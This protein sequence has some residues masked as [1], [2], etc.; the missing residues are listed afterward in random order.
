MTNHIEKKVRL[1]D[2]ENEIIFR[3]YMNDD[4]I[5]IEMKKLE[6]SI[7]VREFMAM[8]GSI[9]EEGAK[10]I[11]AMLKIN[12]VLVHL[13]ISHNY[14]A[15]EGIRYIFDSL[16][17]NSTLTYLNIQSNP[18]WTKGAEYLS[19]MLLINTTLKTLHLDAKEMN[20]QDELMITE[21]LKINSTLQTLCISGVYYWKKK[22]YHLIC[23]NVNW[24]MKM[25]EANYSKVIEKY[26]WMNDLI[27]DDIQDYRS[28]KT[29][30]DTMI[31]IFWTLG[32]YFPRDLIWLIVDRKWLLCCEN[33]KIFQW[34]RNKNILFYFI[35]KK[36]M[37][38]ITKP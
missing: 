38:S 8:Y 6:R 19:K 4:T 2:Y 29:N 34:T 3:A 9:T 28:E 17:T 20:T 1:D 31:F 23:L 35:F 10:D 26:K 25:E 7:V 36:W 14:I 24:N 5:K 12:T 30:K 21:S 32:K 13:D 15:S 11:A 22:M 33:E 16:L 27:G 37:D 18:I